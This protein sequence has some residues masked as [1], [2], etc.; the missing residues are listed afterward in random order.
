MPKAVIFGGAGCVG[1]WVVGLLDS[2]DIC[3]LDP[4]LRDGCEGADIA[5]C[6]A[7]ADLIVIATPVEAAAGTLALA[8][9]HTRANVAVIETLSAKIG[10]HK[11]LAK[12]YPDS[13][14]L[15]L[16]PLFRPQ[17][18]SRNGTVLTVGS[19]TVAGLDF[20][21]LGFCRHA[22]SIEAHD[23]V[24]GTVQALTH[25]NTLAFG[26]SL[27]QV[28]DE[29]PIAQTPP[30]RL[31]NSV[32]ARMMQGAPHVYW[33][34]QRHN[35]YARAARLSLIS[36]LADLSDTIDSN[37]WAG[38]LALRDKLCVSDVAA[39]D[40]ETLFEAILHKN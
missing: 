16:N 40:A 23:R 37:D 18:H 29:Q 27:A 25:I 36:A 31:L 14:V 15:G 6:L 17:K 11:V 10:F 34:I 33:E 9:R 19:E 26:L 8:S 30:F 39:A 13:P 35:S 2:Y 5:I 12:L 32:L 28:Q 38:F 21:A 3:I 4:A 1:Q 22:M 24:L 20:A 7:D